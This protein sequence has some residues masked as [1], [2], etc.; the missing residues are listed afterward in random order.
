M[1]TDQRTFFHSQQLMEQA[2]G[3]LMA[4]FSPL[5]LGTACSISYS[6]FLMDLGNG[7]VG[8]KVMLNIY[9]NFS[10]IPLVL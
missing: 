6:P 5:R 1:T 8:F 2:S 9:E 7:L 3:K 10:F 4:N